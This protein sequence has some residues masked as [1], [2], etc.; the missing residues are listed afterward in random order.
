[1]KN[2]KKYEAHLG[3]YNITDKQLG[4]VKRRL[5]ELAKVPAPHVL[6]VRNREVLDSL[7]DHIAAALEQGYGEGVI[8]DIFVSQG[9]DVSVSVIR[10]YICQLKH[11]KSYS[12]WSGSD[13]RKRAAKSTKK[14]GKSTECTAAKPAA[15]AS[16]SMESPETG[17]TTEPAHADDPKPLPKPES[18]PEPPKMEPKATSEIVIL[19]VKETEPKPAREESATAKPV[20]ATGTDGV[21]K[22]MFSDGFDPMRIDAGPIRFS[23]SPVVYEF[24]SGSVRQMGVYDCPIAGTSGS[25]SWSFR[26]TEGVTFRVFE[27]DLRDGTCRAAKKDLRRC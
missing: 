18:A 21:E 8:H 10:N 12:T 4:D 5:G 3:L 22:P 1:M 24:I 16:R 6:A 27:Q 2:E 23:G 19:S 9:I 14:Q 20:A 26:T 15:P 25:R 11:G 17:K 7:K 13:A